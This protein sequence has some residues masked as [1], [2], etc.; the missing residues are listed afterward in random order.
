VQIWPPWAERAR[1]FVDSAPVLAEEDLRGAEYVGVERLWLLSMPRA[2][3]AGAEAARESLRG[4]ATPGDELRFGALS[5]QPF[6][7]RGPRIAAD[8]TGGHQHQEVG[9][10]ARRCRSIAVPGRVEL[11]GAAGKK[12]HLRAGLAGERAYDRSKPP[13]ELRALVDGAPV[14][15]ITA[16]SVRDPEP[17]WLRAEV[18]LPPGPDERSFTFVAS[19][20]AARPFC[21]AAWTTR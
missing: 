21:F 3:H 16:R 5:L 7:L 4:R 11:R 13:I 19:S 12:L 20:R 18:D 14:A 8:L 1:L 6:E 17:L 15:V 9:Y 2:P 10:V